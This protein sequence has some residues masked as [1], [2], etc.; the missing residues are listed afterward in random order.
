M[1]LT[2]HTLKVAVLRARTDRLKAEY[3]AARADAEQAY[4]PARQAGIK[5][6]TV[7]LPGNVEAGTLSIYKGAVDVAWDEE[8]LLQ[9]TG[10]STSHEVE[11]YVYPAALRDDRIVKLIKEH[12]PEY[13]GRRV[14]ADRLAELEEEVRETGGR[15]LN[16]ATGEMVQVATVTRRDPTGRFAYAPSKRDVAAILELLDAGVLT[17]DGR[18]SPFQEI[19]T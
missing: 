15:L 7:A 12:F 10:D 13:T 14:R 4:K 5:Q 3:E 9:V 6:L 8:K 18:V 16:L 2:D 1:N 17:P 11:D 19:N